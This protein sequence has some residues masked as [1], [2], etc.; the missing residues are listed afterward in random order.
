[1]EANKKMS[2]RLIKGVSLSINTEKNF[3][4]KLKKDKERIWSYFC[5]SNDGNDERFRK[6]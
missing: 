2:D 4:S 6:E 1:M 5:S 3:I